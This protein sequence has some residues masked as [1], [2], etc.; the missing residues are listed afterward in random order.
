[1]NFGF[2]CL[3]KYTKV[4][5]AQQGI[6]NFFLPRFSNCILN[7]ARRNNF[8]IKEQEEETPTE[9]KPFAAPRGGE[10]EAHDYTPLEDIETG[11]TSE[12]NKK[13]HEKAR[14]RNWNKTIEQTETNGQPIEHDLTDLYIQPKCSERVNR[15][16]RW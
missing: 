13:A 8:A 3:I 15:D 1:M 6:H 2:F 9:P 5:N 14:A 7:Y 10:R 12:A 11:C 16:K 4:F